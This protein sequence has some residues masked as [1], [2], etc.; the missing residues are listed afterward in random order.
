MTP[1]YVYVSISISIL[2]I[3]V[4]SLT[5]RRKA[6]VRIYGNYVSA[7]SRDCND[8]YISSITLENLKDRAI[9]IFTIYLRIGYN[10][11]II[12][13]NFEDSPLILKPFETY[14]KNYGPIQF[15]GINSNRIN[16]DSL[17]E[18]AKIKKRIIL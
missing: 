6:G 18:D 2:A 4:A 10:Y 7:S 5:Y 1:W 14:Q 11:Y 13:E 9:T 16:L 8:K 12:I 3:A 17:L 15:Y